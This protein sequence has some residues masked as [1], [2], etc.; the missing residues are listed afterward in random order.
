MDYTIDCPCCGTQIK[1]SIDG[2]GNATAFLL[3]KNKISQDE[4]S[5]DFGIELGIVNMDEEVN[6]TG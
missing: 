3:D 5:N 2:S 1:I 4:L 6:D